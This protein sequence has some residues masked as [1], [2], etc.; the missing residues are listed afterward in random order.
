MAYAIA[1]EVTLTGFYPSPRGVYK[2]LRVTDNVGI[3]TMSPASPL[4][5]KP[6]TNV[7]QLQLEQDN[8]VDGW[9]IHAQSTGGGRFQVSRVGA[10]Q[11]GD[12]F[13]IMNDG[14]VGI[15]TV[16]P[17]EPLD[18]NGV[19][20][21]GSTSGASHFQIRGGSVE[22]GQLV[23]NQAGD[24]TTG[25]NANSWSLDVTGGPTHTLRMFRGT[26]ASAVHGL[27]IVPFGN[28]GIGTTSPG[29]GFLNH[30]TRLHVWTPASSAESHSRIVVEDPNT[31][32]NSSAGIAFKA[33]SSTDYWQWF[34]REGKMIAGIA[35]VPGGD[36]L[37]L[38]NGGNFGI[39]T[40]TP[41]SRLE[42]RAQDP[43]VG[44]LGFGDPDKDMWFDGGTDGYFPFVNTAPS[45]A[46]AA[47]T[48]FNSQNAAGKIMCI[49]N[50]GK[51]GIGTDPPATGSIARFQVHDTSGGGTAQF[52]TNSNA[53]ASTA[54]WLG[55]GC[56]APSW[57]CNFAAIGSVND[58]LRLT[59]NNSWTTP[60]TDV[61]LLEN[62]NVGIG[63]AT[64][65]ANLAVVGLGP[66]GNPTIEIQTPSGAG[67]TGPFLRLRHLGQ[68][69]LGRD[70]WVGS[71][72]GSD[73]GTGNFEVWEGPAVA[74]ARVFGSGNV[75]FMIRGNSAGGSVEA[76]NVGIGTV[77]PVE[78]L[79]VVG[80][81][82][83]SGWIQ[84]DTLFD[85]AE[86]FP[87]ADL[88]L[89]PGDV[90]ALDP[91]GGERLIKA[92]EPYQT[93]L[94]GV[95]SEQAAFRM[96]KGGSDTRLFS[97][98]GRL[99]VKVSLENGQIAVGD[100]LTSSSTPGVAMKATRPGPVIGIALEAFGHG[101]PE[102]VTRG[103]AVGKIL[104]FVHR[105]EH[106]AAEHMSRMQQDYEELRAELDTLRSEEL[107][108]LRA[109]NAELA[110]TVRALQAKLDG[111]LTR[112]AHATSAGAPLE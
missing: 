40:A 110:L 71:A 107:A 35:N 6:A 42:V 47:M 93:L 70:W 11:P 15:G 100:Y 54:L 52:L 78:K 22:G 82:H 108:A 46:A 109:E 95:I 2:A 72:G 38:V 10:D 50:N 7:A 32:G 30:N 25:E 103:A 37:T 92:T 20:I 80:N 29:T 96:G 16:L 77:S 81:I 13:T 111:L 89:G 106:G 74:G 59:A 62:G 99:P 84:G 49:G 64:P 69:V 57:S 18:V 112:H 73:S 58:K 91:A 63:T 48:C 94:V 36:Y 4:T 41:G 65:E 66:A 55:S 102:E 34:S 45:T 12:K 44:T 76:G 87:V 21:V 39:G 79:D 43:L 26:G 3:G 27:S 33:D 28:V 19:G 1:E 14:K 9:T 105:G 88:T 83:A 101:L 61:F 98:E 90:V 53:G 56:S 60:T 23:L 97:L 24:G 68:G 86:Y 75:R 17:A 104:F 8:A 5:I 67:T 85:L 31:F 51:V